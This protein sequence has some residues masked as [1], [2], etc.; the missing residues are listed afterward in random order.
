M[1]LVEQGFRIELVP[2]NADDL[3]RWCRATNRPNDAT[4]REAFAEMV[5][6][7]GAN[8]SPII[9]G[10]DPFREAIFAQ[11]LNRD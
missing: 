11:R 10:D 8:G 5:R 3:A 7:T 4:A 9:A 6:Q 1:D 2:L